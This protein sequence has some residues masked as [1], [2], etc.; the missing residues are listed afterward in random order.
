MLPSNRK[1]RITLALSPELTKVLDNYTVP[2]E[3]S[4][5]FFVAEALWAYLNHLDKDMKPATKKRFQN[6]KALAA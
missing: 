2:F 3:L 1:V 6:Q 4:R 5:S